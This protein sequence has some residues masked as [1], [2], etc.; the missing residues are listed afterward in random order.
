MVDPHEQESGVKAGYRHESTERKEN[1]Y[2]D[3]ARIFDSGNVRVFYR[4]S[5]DHQR[6]KE[7]YEIIRALGEL[8]SSLWKQKANIVCWGLDHFQ[9]VPFI[10]ASDLMTAHPAYRLDE[11]DSRLDG[12]PIQMVV[13]PA[14]LA[15]GNEE[16]KNYDHYKVWAKAVVWCGS[17]N[18]SGS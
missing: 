9:D 8:F 14:I 17:P 7:L 3:M 6:R 5:D 15:Y 4:L 16:G 12:L 1:Y 2:Q 11:G 13:Q 18:G 10:V